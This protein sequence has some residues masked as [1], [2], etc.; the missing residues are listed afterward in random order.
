MAARRQDL[1]S[2]LNLW[3]AWST[4]HPFTR[5]RPMP[6]KLSD[7]GRPRGQRTVLDAALW[8]CRSAFGTC[9]FFSL[10]I[11]VLLLASP[12]YMLQVYDRVLT[13]GHVETLIMV[14]LITATAVACMC[15]LD[16]LR[17]AITIRIG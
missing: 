8:N 11:N 17:T 12:I 9:A 5:V 13:S 16:A 15:A 2:G 7:N 10:I 14:T 4:K 3:P 6:Q 1:A